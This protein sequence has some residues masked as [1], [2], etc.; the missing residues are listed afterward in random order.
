MTSTSN[1]QD[2]PITNKPAVSFFAAANSG[3]FYMKTI[4][5]ISLGLIL[6]LGSA[7]L[8][9][10]QSVS[11]QQQ[12]SQATLST[13]TSDAIV[14]YQIGDQEANQRVWQ[15]I[16]QQ[17]DEQGNTSYQTNNAYTELAT[18][19]NHLVNGQWV[20]SSEKIDI[21]PNGTAATTN[22][23]HQAYFPGNIYQ[24]QIE[25]VT[26]DGLQLFSQPLAL[27][28]FDGTNTVMIAELTNSTGMVAGTNQVIYPDAFTGLSADLRYTYTKA[29]FEQD[30][31][32]HQQPLTP[33]SYGLNAS[34]ARLQMMTEFFNPPAPVVK[35]SGMP[36]QAGVALTD[37]KLGFGQMEMIQGRAFL[38]GD[39]GDNP[40]ARVGKHWVEIQ[41]RQILIEEVPVDAILN[42]LAALPLTAMNSGSSKVPHM[43]SR[44]LI[45]S[46]VFSECQ[47]QHL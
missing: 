44:Q 25:L 11:G 32:L 4:S 8:L 21:L 45:L 31:I 37:Q 24:G 46:S 27:T 9:S 47:L 18:G 26:P 42:G 1:R 19:L 29:G 15:K 30:V 7:G 23:Q 22:G 39:K 14:S 2:S 33:E 20:E 35:P 6:C 17:T 13:T 12:V 3:T 16:V 28:Y 40:G 36:V 43:A 34:T 41:G 10:A 38:L 5:G